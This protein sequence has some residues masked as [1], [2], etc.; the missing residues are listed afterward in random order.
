[1]KRAKIQI[2]SGLKNNLAIQLT[3][4]DCMLQDPVYNGSSV[5]V[6]QLKGA[7]IHD[8]TVEK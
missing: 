1:M 6:D 8:G 2:V 4:Q 3:G 5:R 7:L